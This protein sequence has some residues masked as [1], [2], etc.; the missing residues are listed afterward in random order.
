MGGLLLTSIVSGRIISRTGKYRLFP[1]RR[2]AQG[3]VG[4]V[5]AT[6]GDLNY[7]AKQHPKVRGG[8]GTSGHPGS[9]ELLYGS[10]VQHLRG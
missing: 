8:A 2:M 5:F 1:I 10:E 9:A 3:R 4:C 6:R 7:F